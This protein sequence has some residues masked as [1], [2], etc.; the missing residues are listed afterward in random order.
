MSGS[1]NVHGEIE[2]EGTSVLSISMGS[3][4]PTLD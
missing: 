2:T 3:R 4:K 1:G